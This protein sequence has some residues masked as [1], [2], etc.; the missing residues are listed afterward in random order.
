MPNPSPTHFTLVT[1]SGSDQ[2]LRL[3]IMD[4]LGRMVEAKSNVAANGT[5]QVGHLYRPGVYF[6]EVTQGSKRVVV[7]LVK[8][9]D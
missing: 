5:L 3:R 6:A 2:P 7:R 9:A 8:T 1:K 4:R